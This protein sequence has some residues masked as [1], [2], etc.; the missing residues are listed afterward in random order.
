[1]ETNQ[2]NL[3]WISDCEQDLSLLLS[4]TGNSPVYAAIDYPLGA[5]ALGAG[6]LPAFM[7]GIPDTAVQEKACEIRLFWE[8]HSLL[9]IKRH[10]GWF[11]TVISER[12]ELLGFFNSNDIKSAL[13]KK[14]VQTVY[15]IQDWVRF[16]SKPNNIKNE[17][18]AISYSCDDK[19]RI[20]WRIW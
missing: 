19:E 2:M 18:K 9:A 8:E 13:V 7:L 4:N 5:R 15:S 11:F 20:A 14:T 10:D 12:E 6:F 3:Y 16:I 1:M 17:F